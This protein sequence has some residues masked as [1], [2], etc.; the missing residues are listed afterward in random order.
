MEVAQRIAMMPCTFALARVD[1]FSVAAGFI[2]YINGLPGNPVK[3][4]KKHMVVISSTIEEN[5]L[6]NIT[7][8]F[9]VNIIGR[10]GKGMFIN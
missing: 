5:L 6:K 8:N 9:D 10:G 4:R 2:D 3:N 1:N 7:A